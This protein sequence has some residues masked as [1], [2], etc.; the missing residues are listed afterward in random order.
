MYIQQ[1]GEDRRNLA[2]LIHFV[3]NVVV[4]SL[5]SISTAIDCILYRLEHRKHVSEKNSSRSLDVRLLVASSF[6]AVDHQL[7]HYHGNG[8]DRSQKPPG[9]S[10][11]EMGCS[12]GAPT[13]PAELFYRRRPQL[14]ALPPHSDGS[15]AHKCLYCPRSYRNTDCCG[16]K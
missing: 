13:W 11:S 5:L 6:G 16:Q 10:L 14:G 7:F 9:G 4:V 1:G 3:M 2:F 15:Y 12:A 8:C